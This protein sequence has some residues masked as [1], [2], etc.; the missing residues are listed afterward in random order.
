M[1]HKQEVPRLHI[2]E[3]QAMKRLNVLGMGMEEE[4]RDPTLSGS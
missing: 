2:L 3:L 4:A 1:K